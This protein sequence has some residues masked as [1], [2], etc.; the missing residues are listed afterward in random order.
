M[1]ESSGAHARRPPS[2]VGVVPLVSAIITTCDRPEM[3]ELALRSVQAQT[4]R[5]VEILVCDDASDDR[6][7]K[8][9]LNAGCTDPRIIYCR[10]EPRLG[11][12]S[13]AL[14]GLRQAK[15]EFVAFCHD[16]DT[17]E[18]DFLTRTMAAMAAHPET[19]AVFSD[20]WIMDEDGRLN[21][22]ATE[23]NTRR[24]K[25]NALT[26]DL[27]Q[28]FMELAVADQA[29]PAVMST[30]FRSS[31]LD[32]DDF[33]EEIGAHYDLWLAYLVSRE[34]GAAWYISERLTCD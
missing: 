8:L 17:W 24:W 22:E 12:R 13:N 19:V 31:A 18:P 4:F 29:L 16:D 15:G 26:P 9:V 21:A 32:L 6:T 25:R 10:N 7:A 1:T 2:T 27:H 34:G 20:H 14:S 3:L 23:E 5:D 33:P 28:P 30:L 11:Q